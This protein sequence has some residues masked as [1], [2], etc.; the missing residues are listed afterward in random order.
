[1]GGGGQWGAISRLPLGERQSGVKLK[2]VN[3]LSISR[4]EPNCN[5]MS[6]LVLRMSAFIS[7]QFFLFFYG[8]GGWCLLCVVG[9]GG[10]EEGEYG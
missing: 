6:Q 8:D 1:M 7:P 2:P 10:G 9:G 3:V 5:D 4:R